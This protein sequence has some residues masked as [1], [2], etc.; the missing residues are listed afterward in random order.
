S[1]HTPLPSPPSFSLPQQY[2]SPNARPHRMSLSAESWLKPF[3]VDASIGVLVDGTAALSSPSSPLVLSPQHSRPPAPQLAQVARPDGGPPVP[4]GASASTGV[5]CCEAAA[6]P[7]W[8]L[9]P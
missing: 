1:L 2:T 8:P 7:S 6:G 4:G 9:P 5:G 3:V